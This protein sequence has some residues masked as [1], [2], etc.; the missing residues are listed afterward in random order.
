MGRGSSPLRTLSVYTPDRGSQ[1][2][3]DFLW[4]EGLGWWDT[5]ESTVL[6]FVYWW[7]SPSMWLYKSQ[8]QH[9]LFHLWLATAARWEPQSRLTSVVS[10]HRPC[11]THGGLITIICVFDRHTPGVTGKGSIALF[12]PF[13]FLVCGGGWHSFETTTPFHLSQAQWL[14]NHCRYLSLMLI[15][16]RTKHKETEVTAYL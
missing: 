4:R 8:T 11:P 9:K 3:T 7:T 1:S 12:P 2:T 13:F 14:S 5:S 16:W 6:C 15:V 10:L